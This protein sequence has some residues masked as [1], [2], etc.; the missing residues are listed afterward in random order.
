MVEGGKM[1][2]IGDLVLQVP[3]VQ[4]LPGEVGHQPL[5]LGVGEHAPH[6]SLERGAVV[7]ATLARGVKQLVVGNRTPEEERETR[8]EF[9][10]AQAIWRACWNPWGIALHSPDEDRTREQA[11]QRELDA[12]L[13]VPLL[14]AAVV[15]RDQWLK[16]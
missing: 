10:S 14:A 11:L 4:P 15:E 8:G 6:L 13:E 2:R 1:D 16:V 9:R 5:A 3:Q 12:S 7:E